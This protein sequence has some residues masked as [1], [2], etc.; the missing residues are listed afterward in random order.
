MSVRISAALLGA[1]VIACGSIAGAFAED[2]KGTSPGDA[3]K[4]TVRKAGQPP[5]DYLKAPDANKGAGAT[6]P[7]SATGTI[8]NN[9]T[10][11][12]RR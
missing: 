3:S 10:I 9:G 2:A 4:L 6:T 5:L 12:D 1:L 8:T 7:G 11:N